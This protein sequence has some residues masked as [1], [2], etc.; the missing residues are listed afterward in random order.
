VPARIRA[1]WH[2][3]RRRHVGPGRAGAGEPNQGDQEAGDGDAGGRYP[4]IDLQIPL[5]IFIFLTALGV[6]CN[7][8]LSARIREESRHVGTCRARSAA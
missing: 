4:G 1:A 7:I 5:Y 6:D 8:F 2:P 3:G